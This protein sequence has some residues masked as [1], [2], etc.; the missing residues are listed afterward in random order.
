MQPQKLDLLIHCRWLIPVIPENQILENYTIAVHSGRIIDLIPQPKALQ[1]YSAKQEIELGQHVVMPGLINT[2]SQG[3]MRLLRGHSDAPSM[4]AWLEKYA[5]PTDH[6][7]I[8]S[9]L[10]HDGIRLAMA[11]MIKTGTTCFAEMYFPDEMLIDAVRKVGLRSQISFMVLDSPTYY[12]KNAD[13]YIHRGLQLY[14]STG[15]HPLFKVACA[16]QG[17]NS[18]SDTVI[19]RLST[20]ANELDLPLHI[21]CHKT[22]NEV[23][24]SVT[25]HGCRPLNRLQDMGLLLPQTQLVH[26]NQINPDDMQLLEV[27]NSQVIHCPVSSL[28]TASESCPVS[29]LTEASIN[30]SLGTEGAA[31]NNNLDLFE[32]LKTCALMA[33]SNSN[34]TQT[35]NAHCALRLA[36]INGA[37]TLGWEQEIGTIEAGK[38]ADII[39][40]EID[41]IAQQPLYNPH[42]QLVYSAKS[43]Q[44]SHHWV[45]GKALM[46]DGKL[47]SL[48]EQELSQMAN[49]WSKELLNNPQTAP[50]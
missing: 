4:G 11:E 49:N 20:F 46:I 3:A 33:T 34:E 22:A 2:H 15:N 17:L 50:Q 43:T 42:S 36:T 23:S 7:F 6:K 1:D 44:V 40:I 24:E 12:A 41:P 31:V 26:M 47:V 29:Q 28:K 45:A 37:K 18:I 10:I 27:S 21:P 14:D 30:V 8:D 16:P 9:N 25:K 39:G 19:K 5:Q 13:E 38:Y 32:E 35:L 48:N